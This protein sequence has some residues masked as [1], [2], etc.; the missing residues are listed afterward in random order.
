MKGAD[1]FVA[2]HCCLVLATPAVS[3]N[4]GRE[5]LPYLS[6]LQALS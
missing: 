3:R 2:D 4:V 1:D 6:L 5:G